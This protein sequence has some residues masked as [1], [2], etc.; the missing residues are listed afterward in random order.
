MKYQGKG[1]N[2]Q[3]RRPD[4]NVRSNSDVSFIRNKLIADEVI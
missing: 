3:T 1:F 2:Q 4:V